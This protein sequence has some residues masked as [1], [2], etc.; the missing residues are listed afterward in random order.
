MEQHREWRKLYAK[1]N[2]EFQLFYL[3]WYELK[4]LMT[5]SIKDIY[6][7][8]WKFEIPLNFNKCNLLHLQSHCSEYEKEICKKSVEKCV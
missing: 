6:I 5:H 4:N 2:I 8:Q 3:E 7:F 1:K